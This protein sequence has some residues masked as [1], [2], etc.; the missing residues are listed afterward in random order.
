MNVRA[1]LSCDSTGFAAL[2]QRKA[3]GHVRDSILA[4]PFNENPRMF[5]LT[6]IERSFSVPVLQQIIQLLIVDLQ[7]RAIHCVVVWSDV[8][9]TTLHRSVVLLL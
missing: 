1:G 5:I 2:E 8:C 9:V 3:I 4:L 6:N 7:E